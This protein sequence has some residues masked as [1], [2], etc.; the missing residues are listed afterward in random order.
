MYDYI[1]LISLNKLDL[2]EKFLFTEFKKN[3]GKFIYF[4][5]TNILFIKLC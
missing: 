1:I 5:I 3:H 2:R 4:T